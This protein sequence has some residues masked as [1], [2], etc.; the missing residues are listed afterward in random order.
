[1]KNPHS[2]ILKQDKAFS[3]TMRINLIPD[4]PATPLR[5]KRPIVVK[6]APQPPAP[7]IP[8]IRIKRPGE[9]PESERFDELLQSIYDAVLI[10][11]SDGSIRNVNGRCLQFFQRTFEDLIGTS[12]IDL[13]HGADSRLLQTLVTNLQNDRSTLIMAH[14]RRQ[15][16]STFP[17][18][19]AVNRMRS[20]GDA[21]CFFI[22]DITVR[23][24]AEEMLRTEHCAIQNAA[25]GIA[26]AGR[27]LVFEYVNPA[28]A[29]MLEYDNP[30]L[31]TGVSLRVVLDSDAMAGVLIDTVLEQGETWS[32]EFKTRTQ[33]GSFLD[34]EMV[35]TCNLNSDGERVGFIFSVVDISDRKRAEVTARERERVDMLSRV[36]EGTIR[37][38]SLA[39]ESRDPYTAGHEQNVADLSV[40]I[41]EKLGFPEFRCKGLYYAGLVHDLGKISIPAE[42]LS[43]PGWLCN[44]AMG[45]IRKHP[46]SG[47]NILK[48]VEFPWPIADMVYQHHERMDGSGYP[49]GLC[50]DAILMEARILAVAD[51]VDAMASHRPYRPSLGSDCALEEIELNRGTFYD[52]DVVDACVSL[53]REHGYEIKPSSRGPA[54]SRPPTA[55]VS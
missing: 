17:S 34:L 10:T 40:A 7:G 38:M 44:E 15:D 51:V 35:A 49:R 21:L 31:M 26:I 2:R 4:I 41:A 23:R 42:L 36:V 28:F 54:V 16:G 25:N 19:I 46:E 43:S 27:D 5:V 18:E 47:Y 20:G 45:L 53:F 11:D 6:H 55:P 37:A 29:R 48:N 32:G 3:G 14:C 24:Q 52:A 1:M 30:D 39:V 50:G 12:I 9:K 22:R 13:L 8:R 33:S